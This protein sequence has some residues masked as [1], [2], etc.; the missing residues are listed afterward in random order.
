M[1]E[2]AERGQKE[3]ERG[4]KDRVREID[5]QIHRQR[6]TGIR[7]V[8][9]SMLWKSSCHKIKTNQMMRRRPNDNGVQHSCSYTQS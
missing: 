4:E 9:D 3:G 2:R 5:K 8:K 6:Q 7:L 1:R